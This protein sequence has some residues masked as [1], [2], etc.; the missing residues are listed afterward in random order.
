MD[1]KKLQ[2]T[3]EERE[4]IIL[5]N[6]ASKSCTVYTCSRPVMTKLDKLCISNPK[7]WKLIEKDKES[8]TYST[9]K[10]LISFRSEKVKKILTDEQR[11]ELSV[12]AKKNLQR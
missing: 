8:K 2:L 9:T 4:T 5:F 3:S 1:E 12:R 6:D 7:A 10:N 11:E